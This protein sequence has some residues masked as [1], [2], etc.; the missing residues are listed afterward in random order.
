MPD[1]PP[2]PSGP[3][4][5]LAVLDTVRE[6]VLVL[7]VGLRVVFANRAFYRDFEVDEAE[8]DGRPVG[9]LGSGQWHIPALLDLLGRVVPGD[10]AFEDF[11]VEHD[12]DHIGRR[13]MLLNARKVRWPGEGGQFVLLAIEDVTARRRTEAALAL[14]NRELEEF[15][16]TVSHDL[17]SPLVTITGRVGLLKRHLAAGDAAKVADAVG[18]IERSADRMGHIIDDLLQLSRAGRVV[19]EAA[20]VDVG[21]LVRRL[22]EGIAPRLGPHRCA[23]RVEPAVP[24]V[25]ADEHRLADVFENLLANAVTYG[26]AHGATGVRVGGRQTA[27]ELRYF[28]ADDGPGIA[29]EYHERVFGLFQRLSTDPGGTG[30]G[31]ALVAK[32]MAAHGGR[33]WVESNTGAGATFWIA[34]PGTARPAP[35][36]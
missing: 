21:A 13:T 6:P 20:P 8:T 10:V 9:D 5:D 29:P 3:R 35:S 28:V 14:R 26:C 33:A 32:I 22:W 7:D 24:P 1:P 11:E 31:L 36:R 18:R 30:V 34:F 15:A 19:G 12:F 27:G 4:P 17:K 25:L 16:Y 2:A 23:L